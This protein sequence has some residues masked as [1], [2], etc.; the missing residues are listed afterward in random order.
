LK[1]PKRVQTAATQ[2]GRWCGRERLVHHRYGSLH[3]E[4]KRLD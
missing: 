3:G 1:D 4:G 2:E